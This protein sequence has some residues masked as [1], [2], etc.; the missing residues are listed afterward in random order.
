MGPRWDYTGEF[1]LSRPESSHR[2]GG[3][4]ASLPGKPV[5]C[6][7]LRSDEVENRLPPHF[8]RPYAGGDD[9]FEQ[10]GRR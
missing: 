3:R 9:L 7:N 5:R 4:P 1:P 8:A 10:L 6:W 2:L